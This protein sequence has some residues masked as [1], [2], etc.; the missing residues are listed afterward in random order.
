MPGHGLRR[1]RRAGPGG[2]RHSTARPRRPQPLLHARIQPRSARAVPAG[3]GRMPLHHQLAAGAQRHRAHHLAKEK[4][5]KESKPNSE[6][7]TLTPMA[8]ATN[9]LHAA[10]LRRPPRD[11]TAHEA[12]DPPPRR[13]N[14]G[15]HGL[16]SWRSH[17]G[18]PTT[19]RHDRLPNMAADPT[20]RPVALIRAERLFARLS[21]HAGRAI[22]AV[23]MR[24]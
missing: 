2:R 19:Q 21:R 23:P 24:L 5:S 15:R 13:G 17:P 6:Q 1:H 3:S 18:S 16:A 8:P 9:R 12:A 10:C 14:A 7:P 11:L 4:L 22:R 20:G